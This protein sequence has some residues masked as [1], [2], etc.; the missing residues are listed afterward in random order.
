MSD[1]DLLRGLK[2]T[3][4]ID[5]HVLKVY[6]ERYKRVYLK[7]PEG[8][9]AW[10]E[11]NLRVED[12]LKGEFTPINLFDYQKN[13]LLESYKCD[14]NGLLQ[15]FYA[16]YCW[17]RGDGKSLM[18]QIN[19]LYR[20]FNWRNQTILTA[21]SSK[22]NSDFLIFTEL[23][24]V[25]TN[26]PMLF[27]LVEG[28]DNL[29]EKEVRHPR[30]KNIISPI[31]TFSG[32]KSNANMIIFTELHELAKENYFWDLANSIR[33]VPNAQVV[34]D[35]IASAEGH[36]LHK[37]YETSLK[38][39]EAGRH[40][41][42]DYVCEKNQN[43][44]VTP[45]FLATQRALL[46]ASVYDQNF[47]NRFGGGKR[48]LFNE[49]D[50]RI[51]TYIGVKDKGF[52]RNA[53]RG[54]VEELMDLEAEEKIYLNAK[55][56]EKVR[57]IRDR[58]KKLNESLIRVDDF[59][60]FPATREQ[61]SR[62]AKYIGV[63]EEPIFTIGVDRAQPYSENGDRTVLTVN[64][65]FFLGYEEKKNESGG[66]MEVPVFLHLM[67]D[68]RHIEDNSE[69]EIKNAIREIGTRYN[70]ENIGFEDYETVDIKLWCESQGFEAELIHPNYGNQRM[71][72]TAMF[73]LFVSGL[74]KFPSEC[75]PE[76]PEYEKHDEGRG[77]MFWVELKDFEHD[78]S[79]KKF[80]A[81]S[82]ARKDGIKDD[83]VYSCAWSIFA[84]REI[85][86]VL[87]GDSIASVKGEYYGEY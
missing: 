59:I 34:I 38:N 87:L 60:T 17:A 11:D 53:I 26:S 76:I 81:P 52:D 9:I 37:L 40:I 21:S 5:K 50:R 74:Y 83:A 3:K 51:A 29:L 75:L 7:H 32:I 82:K 10:A 65:R 19:A 16:I 69:Q 23:K 22:E 86:E 67:V 31:S 57:K 66:E 80:Y 39:D 2:T 20:F 47:R 48:K 84:T 13:A 64:A 24:K 85:P 68:Q 30:L 44:L 12:K 36:V 43:P 28:D 61:V 55:D 56:K 73:D 25:I 1:R 62:F 4:D 18:S 15:H 14:A 63:E 46:P 70:I 78:A 71:A 54:A 49:L 41:Y 79:V 72:F 33:G 42:F 45:A 6:K 27:Y 77:R 35:S 58:I 8:V